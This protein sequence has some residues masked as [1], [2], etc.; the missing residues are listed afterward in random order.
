[1]LALTVWIQFRKRRSPVVLSVRV[2]HLKF[3]EKGGIIYVG[4]PT[5]L[6][7]SSHSGKLIVSAGFAGTGKIYC[8]YH[9]LALSELVV[10][11]LFIR[12]IQDFTHL[13]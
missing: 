12:S 11:P 4:D 2:L 10:R 3:Y 9:S 5:T 1:M 7:G 13:C 8:T 6:R